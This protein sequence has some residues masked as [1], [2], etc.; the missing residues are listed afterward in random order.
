MTGAEHQ[1]TLEELE[2][3]VDA[4][5]SHSEKLHRLFKPGHWNNEAAASRDE[6][7]QLQRKAISLAKESLTLRGTEDEQGSKLT[8][9]TS[10]LR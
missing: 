1:F 4:L 8:D 5:G 3:I 7:N 10:G 6:C 2:L 9:T